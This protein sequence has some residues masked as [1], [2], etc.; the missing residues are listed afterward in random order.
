MLEAFE[1]GQTRSAMSCLLAALQK[2][3]P[4]LCLKTAWTVLDS[5]TV[6]T[7]PKQAPAIPPEAIMALASV[8]VRLGR[9]VE[10]TVFMICYSALLRAREALGLRR[11]DHIIST[12]TATILLGVAKRGLE[13]KVV[14]TN[15]A[16][17][18]WLVEYLRRRGKWADSDLLFPVSFG[19]VL[20]QL[21]L[22]SNGL[23]I[24]AW[25]VTTHSFRRSGASE[26]SRMGL[27]LNDIRLY[28]RWLSGRSVRE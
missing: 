5:R 12:C 17:V 8:G 22:L 13:Q 9:E 3:D 1:A 16:V 18:W 20:Y 4:R 25:C 2:V 26:L 19:R 24:D 7:P 28:G 14:L 6:H 23:G 21:R 10:A 27:A 15:R 11:C